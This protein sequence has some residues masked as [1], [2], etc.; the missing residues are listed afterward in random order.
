MNDRIAAAGGEVIAI[1]VDSDERCAAMFE[2]WPMPH[3]QFV[4]DPGGD[5]YLKALDLFDPEERGGIAL[6]ALLVLDKDGNEVYGYRGQDFA[7]RRNDDDVI[8]ALEGLGLDAIEPVAGG[9]VDHDVDVEQK[10]AFTPKI[11]RP[12]FSG[13]KFGAIAIRGRAEGDEAKTLAK[14]HQ[15]MAQTMLDAWAELNSCGVR[16]RDCCRASWAAT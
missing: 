15:D 14:E 3:V 12:Y 16:I 5:T 13:N 11:F 1:S 2:R 10:G 7:D 8:G 6:P 4:S 9:P